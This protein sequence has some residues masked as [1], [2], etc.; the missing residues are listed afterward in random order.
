MKYQ[1]FRLIMMLMAFMPLSQTTK[2]DTPYYYLEVK[3]SNIVVQKGMLYIGIYNSK[4][5]F[6]N[7]VYCKGAAIAVKGGNMI[8]RVKLPKGTYAIKM[9]QDTNEDGKM[10]SIFGIPLEPYGISGNKRG[11]PKFDKSCF[12]LNKRMVINVK[13]K[14]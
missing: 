3:I 9:Y 13:L 11:F 7:N 6:K 8:Y 1:I 12:S 4:E 2:A 14:N 5:A 10:N